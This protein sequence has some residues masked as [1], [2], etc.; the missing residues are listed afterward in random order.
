ME[1]I[2]ESNIEYSHKRQSSKDRSNFW[3][4]PLQKRT[5]DSCKI[6]RIYQSTWDVMLNNLREKS[7]RMR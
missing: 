5:D 6:A 4:Y 2:T 3:E 7:F 1:W